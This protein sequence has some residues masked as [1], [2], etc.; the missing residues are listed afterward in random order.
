MRLF[1]TF[2]QQT[3][4]SRLIAAGD[5]TTPPSMNDLRGL[6]IL[7]REL[8]GLFYYCRRHWHAHRSFREWNDLRRE[9]HL[10]NLTQAFEDVNGLAA[11]SERHA[12]IILRLAELVP[13]LLRPSGPPPQPLRRGRPNDTN[14]SPGPSL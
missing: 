10:S 2:A 9:Q 11:L 7:T 3:T 8:N 1:E 6:L 12:Y 5:Y 13:H 14:E 4:G